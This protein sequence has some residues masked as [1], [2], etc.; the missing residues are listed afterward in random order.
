MISRECVE[1]GYRLILGRDA[2]SE[3]VIADKMNCSD[4]RDLTGQL[5]YSDEFISKQPSFMPPLN[6]WVMAEH[7]LDFKI[8]VNLMDTAISWPILRNDFENA[9]TAFV[10]S[11]LNEGDTAIDIGTNIGYF[12]MLFS[13]LVGASGHVIGFEPMPFLFERAAMSVQANGFTQCEIHNVALAKQDGE[14]LLVYAPGSPNWGGAFLSFDGSVL[15][16]HASVPVPIR[17][18]TDYIGD[19]SAKLLKIDVEGG[20]YLVIE[21]AID[22]LERVKPIILSEIHVGQLQR[23]SGVTPYDY[24]SLLSSAGYRCFELLKNG[25]LGKE[26]SG[27][28]EFTV[29]NV[30]F[31]ANA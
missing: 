31:L 25:T 17:V 10:K 5:I 1:W 29:L 11:C 21:S 26:L 15:P 6:K 22:Y 3:D 27:S 19:T 4:Y 28:E 16:D 20:E 23:V 24:I 30:V 13:R 18:L 12:A 7:A 2:E 14:A 9:E 8:W